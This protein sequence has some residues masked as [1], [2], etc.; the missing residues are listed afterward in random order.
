MP[1]RDL[2]E[3]AGAEGLLGGEGVGAGLLGAPREHATLDAAARLGGGRVVDLLEDAGHDEE[4]GGLEG[5]DVGQQV[6]DVGGEAEHA[7]AGE[8]DVHDKAGEHVGDG[9]EEQEAG[10]GGVDDLAEHL[11][12]TLRGCNE[13]RVREGHALGVPG[14]A[15][16]VDDGRDVGGGHGAHGV[17]TSSMVTSVAARA[18]LR[19]GSLVEGV[20]R[21]R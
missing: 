11:A 19:M 10:L 16:R 15:G 9:Q 12:R 2:L 4:H 1:W 5:L 13:V 21:E 3:G 14:R 7:L 20:D 17:S 18:I 8:D 6:L